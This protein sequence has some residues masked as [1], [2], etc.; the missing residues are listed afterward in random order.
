MKPTKAQ[1][2]QLATR[3]PR[4]IEW[5]Q[6]DNAFVGSAPPLIGQ[7]CHGNTEAEVAK[8]LKVIVEDLCEDVLNGVVTNPGRPKTKF[9]GEFVVRLSPDLHKKLYLLS[10]ARNESL[11]QFIARKLEAV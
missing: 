4:V 6:E 9:S 11:N 1:I 8:Q 10:E 5:S 3:Y 2:R 7:C